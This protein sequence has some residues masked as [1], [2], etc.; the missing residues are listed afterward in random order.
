MESY[1]IISYNIGY[2]LCYLNRY[3]NFD[4]ASK[5]LRFSDLQPL[6]YY[7]LIRFLMHSLLNALVIF[8]LLNVG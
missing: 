1:R 7:C 5:D 8:F 6:P 4:L 3:M 2:M